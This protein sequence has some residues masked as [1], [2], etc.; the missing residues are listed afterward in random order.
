LRLTCA[1]L[2]TCRVQPPRGSSDDTR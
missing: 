1:Q 2:T